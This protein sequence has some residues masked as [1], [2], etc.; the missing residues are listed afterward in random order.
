MDHEQNQPRPSPED[1][2]PSLFG[3]APEAAP[4]A[5]YR[6]LARKYR[7]TT[8]ASVIGQEP[9]LVARSLTRCGG[10]KWFMRIFLRGPEE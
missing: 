2:G 8:F 10:K 5:A 1:A 6:V 9:M 4:A 7:P 3:A